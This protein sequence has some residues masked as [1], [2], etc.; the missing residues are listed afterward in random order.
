MIIGVLLFSAIVAIVYIDHLNEKE[1]N[2][3]EEEME[4]IKIQ[5]SKS[6]Q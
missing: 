1:E 5:K 6:K 4:R 3:H 2:R